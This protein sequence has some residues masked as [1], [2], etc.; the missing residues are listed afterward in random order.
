MFQHGRQ[1]VSTCSALPV[2]AAEGAAEEDALDARERDQALAEVGGAVRGE[3]R[4]GT[5]R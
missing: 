5:E 2:D 1:L 3:G 4:L